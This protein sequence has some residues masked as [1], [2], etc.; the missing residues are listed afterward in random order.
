MFS[1]AHEPLPQFDYSAVAADVHATSPHDQHQRRELGPTRERKAQGNKQGQTSQKVF[2]N[3]MFF[4]I[5]LFSRYERRRSRRERSRSSSS[6]SD[7]KVKSEP[8]RN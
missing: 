5:P 4:G 6:C 2:I 1:A 8:G 3:F 7:V